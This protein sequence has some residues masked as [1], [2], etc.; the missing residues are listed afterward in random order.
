MTSPKILLHR[1]DPGRK[2]SDVARGGGGGGGG[3]LP[4]GADLRGAPKCLDV[5]YK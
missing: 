1:D 3:Q 5:C 4:P 2:F